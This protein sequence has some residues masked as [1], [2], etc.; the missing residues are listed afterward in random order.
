MF[1]LT[2][3][4]IPVRLVTNCTT[5]VLPPPACHLIR[6][7]LPSAATDVMRKMDALFV[8]SRPARYL[9]RL[10]CPVP[11]A[12]HVA[13][14]RLL[15]VVPVSSTVEKYCARHES[16]MPSPTESDTKLPEPYETTNTSGNPLVSL[17]ARFEA[18]DVKAIRI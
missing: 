9:N 1:W 13:Q 4:K 18:S 2:F 11:V 15:V 14:E 8:G 16:G 12:S 5:F 6:I 7:E 17:L 10:F 3:E